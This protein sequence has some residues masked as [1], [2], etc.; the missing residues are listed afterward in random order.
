LDDGTVFFNTRDALELADSNGV[1]D[2]YEYRAG[3]RQLISGGRNTADSFFA[4]ASAN[5]DDV[6]F[7]TRQR[8]VRQDVDDSIDVYDARRGGGIASQDQIVDQPD[9]GDNVECRSGGGTSL[10]VE[11]PLTDLFESPGNEILPA[12]SKRTPARVGKVNVRRTR[13]TIAVKV[14]RA[15]VVWASGAAVRATRR[16][17]ARR[18]TYSVVARLTT[19]AARR[20]ARGKGLT[21]RVR[22]R[23]TVGGAQQSSTVVTGKLHAKGVGTKGQ[24][25]AR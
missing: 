7:Y 8:L 12:P 4:D 17:L 6:Y 15:G 3:T 14:P 2:A 16:S 20:V 1:I 13:V 10:S 23:F 11:R 24:R 22:I 9:C 21:V 25:G 18:G 5:G 19:S